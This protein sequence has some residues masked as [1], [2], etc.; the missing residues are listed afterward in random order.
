MW[1][2][3]APGKAAPSPYDSPEQMATRGVPQAKRERA[4]NELR[5]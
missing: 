3:F 2:V 1:G 4:P 5:F